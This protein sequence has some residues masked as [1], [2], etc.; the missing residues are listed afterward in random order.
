MRCFRLVDNRQETQFI[1][2]ILMTNKST[3]TYKVVGLCAQY[4]NC[5][6]GVWNLQLYNCI[7]VITE[8]RFQLCFC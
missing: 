2:F 5:L 7:A 1:V 6:M 3:Y 8:F 4:A